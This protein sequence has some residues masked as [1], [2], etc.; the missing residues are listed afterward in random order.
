MPIFN[1]H[2]HPLPP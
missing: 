1:W 2:I